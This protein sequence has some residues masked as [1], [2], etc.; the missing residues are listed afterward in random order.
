MSQQSAN[1]PT[2]QPGDSSN[3]SPQP[4]PVAEV[5]DRLRDVLDEKVTAGCAIGSLHARLS[6][7]VPRFQRDRRFFDALGLVSE[8]TDHW[9]ANNYKKAKELANRGIEMLGNGVPLI[10]SSPPPASPPPPL[11]PP[12]LEDGIFSGLAEVVQARGLAAERLEMLPLAVEMVNPAGELVRLEF[13][14]YASDVS[15][16][17]TVGDIARISFKAQGGELEL[18]TFETIWFSSGRG[19]LQPA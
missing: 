17:G 11:K 13:Q 16:S 4:G 7:W 3:P 12:T 19:R 18:L 6:W 8:A 5:F 2:S 15:F 10:Q 14:K 9:F 1:V